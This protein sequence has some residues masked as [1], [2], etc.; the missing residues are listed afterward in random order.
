MGKQ[1]AKQLEEMKAKH[2]SVGD[3]RY[4][5]L[6]SVIETVKNKTTKEPTAGRNAKGN[7]LAKMKE[8]GK[9]LSQN[10]LFTY[11]SANMIF[12][13]PPLV[14]NAAELDEGLGIIDDALKITDAACN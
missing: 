8:V 10:G 12:I 2:A 13:V 11:I 5:G 6:F 7:E 14:I 4:I 1:L 9:Y 3:V